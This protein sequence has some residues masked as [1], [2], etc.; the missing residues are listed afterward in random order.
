MTLTLTYGD[1]KMMIMALKMSK[2]C[3]EECDCKQSDLAD[4]LLLLQTLPS[5]SFLFFS[6]HKTQKTEKPLYKHM[7]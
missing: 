6:L 5:Y 1:L 4:N 2:W 3:K 7:V